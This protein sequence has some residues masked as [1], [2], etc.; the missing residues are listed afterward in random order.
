MYL[1]LD[2]PALNGALSVS[3]AVEV[4]VG[5][6]VLPERKVISL[7]PTDGDIWFGFSSSDLDTKGS[8]IR[9]GQYFL[10][11][12]TDKLPAYIQAVSGT[13]DVRVSEIA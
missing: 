1:P 10:I 7:Q 3:T 5:A 13:V 4:K 2:G 9:Q 12:C 11:E 6:S 8:L